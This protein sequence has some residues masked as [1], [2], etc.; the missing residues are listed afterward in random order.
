LSQMIS[1]MIQVILLLAIGR[2]LRQKDILSN[3]AAKGIRKIIINLT[4]PTVLFLSFVSMELSKEYYLLVLLVFVMQSLFLG[5]S[6]LVNKIKALHHPLVPFFST[7]CSFAFI[8]IPF[9][10]AVY[11]LEELGQYTILGVGH[12][13]FVWMFFFPGLH[14]TMHQEKLSLKKSLKVLTSP[15]L[16]A[17]AAGIL[18]NRFQL[19]SLLS[20]SMVYQG[21]YMTVEALARITSP[22]I[23]M[24]IGF[25]IQFSMANL[26]DSLKLVTVRLMI[27]L[28]VG[29]A[30]KVFVIDAVIPPTPIFNHAFFTFLVIPPPMV[31][32]MFAATLLSKEQGDLASSAMALHTVVSIV[33]YMAVVLLR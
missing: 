32:P 8:G 14:L 11:G 23:L 22:L 27:I 31:I 6:L 29:Y 10:L 20:P 3:E 17:M 33:L 2:T 18:F 28:G 30:L 5:T 21:I 24:M 19:N 4:L 26:K 7:G 16:M 1:Q 25:G 15:V 9:F 12:E 13:L